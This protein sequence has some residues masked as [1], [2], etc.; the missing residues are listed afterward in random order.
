MPVLFGIAVG[1]ALGALSRYGITLWLIRH[2]SS[3]F[4]WPTLVVNVIGSFLLGLLMAWSTRYPHL[5]E[6]VKTMLAIGFLGALTTF[7]TFSYDTYRL[8]VQHSLSLGLINILLQVV[9]C[10]AAVA[11]SHWLIKFYY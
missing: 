5:P 1:G 8:M 9:L 11:A 7:S 6:A 4:A 3:V 10:L 2:Q